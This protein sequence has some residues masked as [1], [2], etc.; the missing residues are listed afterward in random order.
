MEE[1]GRT[2]QEALVAV[3]MKEEVQETVLEAV[4]TAAAR[5]T[6]GGKDDI[7]QK[8][9]D[10]E[11]DII[12]VLGEG[13]SIFA[14]SGMLLPHPKGD[15]VTEPRWGEAVVSFDLNI[16]EI[17]PEPI[18][19]DASDL[20]KAVDRPMIA[21]LEANADEKRGDGE[22]RR[23]KKIMESTGT[24][25]PEVFAGHMLREA[26]T[27]VR[28]LVAGEGLMNV[29]RGIFRTRRGGRGG[30]TPKTGSP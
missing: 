10:L 15:W 13:E 16:E 22:G 12:R 24:D 18:P 4:R 3:V 17:A 27:N 21:L 8:K 28:L 23:L 7:V 19:A 6:W 11:T 2:H 30:K 14:Q 1:A 9:T 20:E 25:G 5:R 29:V 26:S